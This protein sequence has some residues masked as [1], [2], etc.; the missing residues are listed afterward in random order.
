MR[1]LILRANPSQYGLAGK[2]QNVFLYCFCCFGRNGSRI[3][4][5]SLFPK[6]VNPSV[7]IVT[8]CIQFHFVRG[9]FYELL[10]LT[11]LQFWIEL[12]KVTSIYERGFNV[13]TRCHIW[14]DTK[15]PDFVFPLFGLFV[16]EE[17]LS[18]TESQ[19]HRRGSQRQ[20]SRCA[21]IGV[22]LSH[23]AYPRRGESAL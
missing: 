4:L 15:L 17:V 20:L 5:L 14:F 10:E 19:P 21:P 1:F 9:F 16:G 3:H 11:S 13:A 23:S 6:E 12:L 18:L 8:L 7:H 2:F 22:L